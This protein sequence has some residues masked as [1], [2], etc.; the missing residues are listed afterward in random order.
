MAA[1]GLL[2]MA[3][4]VTACAPTEREPDLV[5]GKQLFV[6]R[7]GAC[8]TLSRAATVG[9]RGP[10]LDDAFRQSKADGL[11]ESSI[12]SFVKDQILYPNPDGGMPAKL[13]TGDDADDVAAY[14]ARAAAVAGKDTGLLAEVGQGRQGG[15]PGRQVFTGSAGCGTCHTLADAGTTATSGPDL[16]EA[17][18]GKT[19]RFIR[20]AIVDP[21]AEIAAGFSPG[22]MPGNYETTLSKDD[23]AALVDYL[24]KTTR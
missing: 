13:V 7:C 22:V 18:K 2:V 17:L 1:T 21:D 19:P 3:A 4:A 12:R 6:Q 9:T 14:V 8:H 5:N 10:D 11:R 23:L 20:E 16:D 15:P 24:S